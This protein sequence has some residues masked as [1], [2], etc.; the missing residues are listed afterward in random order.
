MR[1]SSQVE[2]VNT[3][4]DDHDS[5]Y[6]NSHE[7]DKDLVEVRFS[8]SNDKTFTVNAAELIKAINNCVNV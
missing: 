6:L 5:L 4:W 1:N 3:G 8:G 2:C 7:D